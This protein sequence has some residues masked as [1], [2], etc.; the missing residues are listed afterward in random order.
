MASLSGQGLWSSVVAPLLAWSCALESH[1]A[2]GNKT[3]QRLRWLHIVVQFGDHS[4]QQHGASRANQMLKQED[5]GGE[6]DTDSDIDGGN[7]TI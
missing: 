3:L 4:T 7:G 1:M 6:S 5:M 2:V